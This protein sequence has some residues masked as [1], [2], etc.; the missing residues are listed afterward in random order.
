MLF[1]STVLFSAT[2]FCFFCVPSCL[3]VSLLVCVCAFVCLGV[4]CVAF[5]YFVC[6][7]ACSVL[8]WV[9]HFLR[10]LVVCAYD[11]L[12]DYLLAPC[13]VSG[14]ICLFSSFVYS[15]E[16]LFW[17]VLV[18]CFFRCVAF[19]FVSFIQCCF[20]LVVFGFVFRLSCITRF[21]AAPSGLC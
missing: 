14:V 2:S 11:C 20:E 19:C 6:L 4:V 10:M 3:V 18:G 5:A 15:L 13:L 9:Y 12:S 1:V 8:V 16:R 17:L 21:C 7:C